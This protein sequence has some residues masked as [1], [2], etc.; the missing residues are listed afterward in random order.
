MNPGTPNA[1]QKAIRSSSQHVT[2]TALIALMMSSAPLAVDTAFA[3]Q[4]T[5]TW[6]DTLTV[7]GTRTELSVFENPASVSVIEGQQ[8]DRTP[9]TSVAEMLRD[10][11]GVEVVDSS[12]P[13]MKRIRIRGESSRRVTVLV[14][15]QE[16][17][18][19]STYGTPI[20]V[21]PANIERIEVVRGP[22]SVL[23][24]AKAIGGVI[25]IITKRGAEK[26]VQL[27]IGGGYYSGTDGWQGWAALSGTVDNFDY[28]ISGGLDDHKDRRVPVGQYTSTGRLDGSSFNNDNLSLH[29]GYRFGDEGNHYVALKAE[30]HRLSTESWTDPAYLSGGLRKFK[31][32]LPQR[33]LRKVGVYYDGKDLGPVVRNVHLDFYYQTVDRLFSNEVGVTTMIPMADPAPPMEMMVDVTSTSDDRIINYG[34][35]A[36]VDLQLHPDHYTIVGLHYLT[37]TLSTT[38]TT[39]SAVSMN[40]AAPTVTFSD[41]FDDASIHTISAFAQNEWSVTDALKLITGARYYH[42]RTALNDSSDAARLGLADK[43]DNRV[44]ASAGLTYTGIEDTTLRAQFSQGYITPTLLQLFTD[45]SAGSGGLSY[46][47]PLLEPETSWNVEV[48]ARYNSGDFVFDA[49]AF[50]TRARNYIAS[51]PCASAGASCP[52]GWDTVS[53][54]TATYVNTDSATTYGVELMAEYALGVSGFT[55]YMSGSWTRRQLDFATHSTWNSD[56]PALSGRLGVRWEGDLFNHSAWADLFMRAS[57]G[58]KLTTM[59]NGALVTD[60]LPAYG[61]LNFAFGGTLGEND[62]F[63]YGIHFNNILDK[64]YRTSFDEIPGTGRSIELTA[65]MKF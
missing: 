37:D 13:G 16:I 46:G 43:S 17:T 47:N 34:G 10:V 42:T 28:R 33:D 15:G 59:E 11:P 2:K 39:T 8:L 32:D 4:G 55:P 53:G 45:S 40:G 12:A 60:T 27:E 3:Q 5:P 63:R 22:A 49:A 35:T 58:V 23:Y 26:A 61:T 57:S 20:L 51:V 6:L 65:R 41:G 25:N 48:G 14:D 31:I 9:P 1:S 18:D 62:K 24:G 30:Q 52:T 64:E 50:Y 19:H 21:D 38:K 44:V 29:M 54:D 7:V 56:T 36:Q